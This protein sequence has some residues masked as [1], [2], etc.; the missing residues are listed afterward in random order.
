MALRLNKAFT[1]TQPHNVCVWFLF[2]ATY[3]Y[4]VCW[5]M[6][7]YDNGE[8]IYQTAYHCLLP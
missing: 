1:Q 3:N 8:A 5:N 6:S 4:N 2:P 7:V